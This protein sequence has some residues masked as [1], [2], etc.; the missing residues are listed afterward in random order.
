MAGA[1]M[2]MVRRI[3]IRDTCRGIRSKAGAKFGDRCVVRSGH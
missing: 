2:A 3:A 1:L